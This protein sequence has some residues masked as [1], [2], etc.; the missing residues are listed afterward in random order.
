M[1]LGASYNLFDGEELLKDSILS[2]RDNVDYISVVFQIVSNFGN[3]AKSDITGLLTELTD[4]GLIDEVVHYSPDLTKHPHENEREKRN[5]GL[6]LSLKNGCSHHISMDA[7]EFYD[8]EQ[9]KV[10]KSIIED[11]DFD[12]SAC[13]LL[14]YYRN[15]HTVL[16]PMEDYFVPF[17]YRIYKNSLFEPT[18]WPVLVDPTRRIIPGKFH[19]FTPNWLV[20]H[21][22]SYV[23][24]NIRS[25]LENSSAKQNWDQKMMGNLIHHYS[26]WQPGM[27]ALIAPGRAYA[28]KQ[29]T[30]KF[31]LS[32]LKT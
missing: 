12:S 1:K 4:Q 32:C 18:E 3:Y 19:E 20:M 11:S 2:I 25:K 17:I 30:P 22:F 28:T 14:T 24:N 16:D 31:R 26:Q 13:R 29:I 9:F 8:R 7:D 10:A 27:D 6:Q 23:R 21:H 15:D 5:I